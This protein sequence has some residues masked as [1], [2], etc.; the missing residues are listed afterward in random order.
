MSALSLCLSRMG[1]FCCTQAPKYPPSTGWLS[2][3]SRSRASEQSLCL[4]VQT[5]KREILAPDCLP[6][7]SCICATCLSLVQA[8]MNKE[9]KVS[10]NNN[11]NMAAN[12]IPSTGAWRGEEKARNGHK[13]CSQEAEPGQTPKKRCVFYTEACYKRVLIGSAF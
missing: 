8:D 10:N 1:F 3:F 11:I 5:L 6:K 2:S 9:K 7:G 13:S 4:L 12:A